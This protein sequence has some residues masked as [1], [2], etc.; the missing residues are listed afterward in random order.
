VNSRNYRE[1]LEVAIMKRIAFSCCAH[2]FPG[3]AAAEEVI[4]GE[5]LPSNVPGIASRHPDILPRS[6]VD[7][8]YARRGWQS[9]YYPRV[10]A[11]AGYTLPAFNYFNRDYYYR[12][13]RQGYASSFVNAAGISFP[14]FFDF[15]RRARVD[16]K[17]IWIH[18]GRPSQH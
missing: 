1:V 7:V 14:E 17:L 6:N 2:L 18:Q 16:I 12:G 5:T 4:R 8:Y 13:F 10:D 9:G 3:F 15:W 11:L